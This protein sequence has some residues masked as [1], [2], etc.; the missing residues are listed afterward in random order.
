MSLLYVIDG[1]NLTN[2][3]AF[4]AHKKNKTSAQALID[5]MRAK[6]LTGSLKNKAIV[7]FDGYPPANEGLVEA[8]GTIEVIYSRDDSADSKIKHLVERSNNPKNII[9]VSDDREIKF[10]IRFV[11]AHPLSCGEFI[12]PGLKKNESKG[13]LKEDLKP[14]VSYTQM[15][16]INE[17][18]RKLWLE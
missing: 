6:R 17:E 11:G 3:S 1:Y 2:S 4:S 5:L 8:Q 18:L 14:E 7:V 16:K 15:H 10:F 13:N 12:E 9:V